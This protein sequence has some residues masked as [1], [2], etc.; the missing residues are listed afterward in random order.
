MFEAALKINNI[1][2]IIVLFLLSKN[3]NVHFTCL[4]VAF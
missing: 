4:A 1:K 2:L 3:E